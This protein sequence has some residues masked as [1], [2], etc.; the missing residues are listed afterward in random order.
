M[1]RI[2]SF[3]PSRQGATPPTAKAAGPSL[4][5][6]EGGYGLQDIILPI[7]GNNS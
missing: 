1:S 2:M 5:R 4:L 3:R 7:Y 6:A